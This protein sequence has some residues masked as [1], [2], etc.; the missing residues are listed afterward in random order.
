MNVVNS[1]YLGTHPGQGGMQDVS[2]NQ[3]VAVDSGDTAL[4]LMVEYEAVGC[5]PFFFYSAV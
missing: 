2:H 5:P 1:R 4:V 3:S